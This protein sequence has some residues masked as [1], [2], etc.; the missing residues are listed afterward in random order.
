MDG[1]A[2]IEASARSDQ[3]ISCSVAKSA[4]ILTDTSKILLCC[5]G[6]DT[7]ELSMERS[8]KLGEVPGN[9]LT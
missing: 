7:Q 4:I 5:N 9:A 3:V 2:L 8:A 1:L 6:T